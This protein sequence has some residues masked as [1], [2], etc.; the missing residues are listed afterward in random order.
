MTT[1]LVFTLQLVSTYIILNC[2][3][4]KYR[5]KKT[6][7]LKTKEHY[8]IKFREAIYQLSLSFLKKKILLTKKRRKKTISN[9][10]VLS[11]SHVFAWRERSK[12]MNLQFISGGR[13]QNL[14]LLYLLTAT[15]TDSYWNLLNSDEYGAVQ[16]HAMD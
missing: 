5:K 3:E 2:P 13:H 16:L 6:S 8:R 9:N 14:L 4:N 10:P 15:L 7:T 1:K 11:T 12:L